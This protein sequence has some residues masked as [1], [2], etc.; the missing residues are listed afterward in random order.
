MRTSAKMAWLVLAALLAFGGCNKSATSPS[1]NESSPNGNESSA[2]NSSNAANQPKA[3]NSSAPGEAARPAPPPIVIPAG[4]VLTVTVDQAVSSKTANPG[5][6]FDASLAEPVT[7]NGTEVLRI[8][9][10][11]SGVVSE[12]QSAGRFNG[13]ALL[14][15]ALDEITVRGKEYHLRTSSVAENSKGRGKRTGIGAGGGAAFGAIVGAIA[16]G[17]KGAA[18]GALAGGGAG[19]AGAAFTGKRDI[20][21]PAETRLDFKLAEP[22]TISRGA[23]SAQ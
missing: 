12:A 15:L 8:G 22:V 18:I 5:D 1:S 21:V 16:G 11:V 10:R 6:H 3:P 23:S 13:H 9:T 4:T 14:G 19:T 17:G 7:V 20:T 2:T